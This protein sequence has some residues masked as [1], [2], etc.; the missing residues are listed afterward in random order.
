LATTKV[1]PSDTNNERTEVRYGAQNVLDTELQFFSKSKTRI[2]TCMNYT[3][4][5]L[6][7]EIG[8]IKKAFIDAK[9]RGVRLRYVAEITAENISFCKEL[10]KI[11]SELR[12][13]DGVKGNFML[14]ESEYVAPLILYSEG[15]VASQI[16]YSN[17]KEVIEHQQY[18]FDALWNKSI[19]ADKRI[20]EI[21]EGVET[22][23]TKVLDNKA[24]IFDYLKSI[25][26]NTYEQSTC[27]SIGGM[28][29][30]YNNFFDDY[31]K[32]VDRS[33]G[34]GEN[35]GRKGVRWITSIVD[36]DSIDL[37][38]IFLNVGMQV[39]HIKN[40]T[41]MDFAVDNK[42]FNATIDKMEGGRIM[43]SLLVSNEPAY[44]KHYNSVFE[45]L[46][47]TGI[48]A[49]ERIRDIEAGVDL[50]DIEIVA[51]SIRVQE[52]FLNIVKMA[53]EEILWILP[54][55]NAFIN[56]EKIGAIQLAK[57]AAK[58]RKVKVRI[59]VPA[60]SLI[61][62]KLQQ[63]KEHCSGNIDVRYIEQMSETKATILVVDR[64]A[65]LVMELRDDSKST[66]F[67]AIGLSTYSNSKEGVLSY[68]AIFENLW[69]QTELYQQVKNSNEQLV[70]VNE[71]LKEHD[72]MQR[73]F[74]NIASHELKTPTQA[75]LGYS[76]LIQRHPERRDEMI[77]AIER[78]AIRLQSLTNSILDVSRIESQTLK[79][80]KE[81]FNINEK[82]RN[83]VDD[84]KSKEEDEI[85]IAFADPRVDPIVVEADKTRIYEVI[86]NLLANAIKFTR[87]SDSDS[88]DGINTITIFTDIKSIQADKESS[89][90]SGVEE[91]VIISVRDRGTGID[92][93]VQGKLFSKFVTTSEAGSGLG[94]FIS[95]GIVEAHGGRI[96]AQNNTD[97][98]GATFSFSLA[99]IS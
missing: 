44:I 12:H 69:K 49:M 99:I 42:N 62:Q 84:T 10:L 86:S 30:V 61:E 37:A 96:W 34:R 28:K 65:S 91:E 16:V 46:W 19:A 88:S 1:P 68:V 89:S 97:G 66:F 54:T 64:K 82:V 95:K 78:N 51:S 93:N 67:E 81:K 35:K 11:V 75:I 3:R 41:H 9:N 38:R 32:I 98:R 33:R 2:D 18:V 25:S 27:C 85:E 20:R 58:Q 73:E 7:I 24:E 94:L 57:Q 74:I 22:T 50:A 52:I 4:P 40:L 76:V 60:N 29:L 23:Q 8:L 87:K 83:V 92:P 79:L 47:K 21:E 59:L 90:N 70:S 36:K 56:Q 45:E 80:N 5:Q 17:I 31:K 39:R 71:Q 14:S 77:R 55:K 6:A 48:D 53:I 63:L 43:E 72:K 13:L 26:E 15:E